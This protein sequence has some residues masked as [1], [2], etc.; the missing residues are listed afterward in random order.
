M[1][2]EERTLLVLP[3]W[4]TRQTWGPAVPPPPLCHNAPSATSSTMDLATRFQVLSS[5]ETTRP[6][7]APALLPT[8]P[9]CL[10]SIRTQLT[11]FAMTSVRRSGSI[12]C[13]LDSSMCLRRRTKPTERWSPQLV[14]YRA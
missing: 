6:T 12:R 4:A 2:R 11:T 8:H 1:V 5:Q 10:G 9:T 14:I 7:E 3:D 13:S